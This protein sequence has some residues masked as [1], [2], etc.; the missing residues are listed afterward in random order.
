M[1]VINNINGCVILLYLPYLYNV[2]PLAEQCIVFLNQLD[3]L[4]L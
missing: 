4:L 1:L 2:F 3:K